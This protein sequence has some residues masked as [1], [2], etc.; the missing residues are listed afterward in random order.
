MTRSL[1]EQMPADWKPTV[2]FL[3]AIGDATLEEAWERLDDAGQMLWLCSKLH[4][5]PPERLAWA[6]L[7]RARELAQA[8]L[9]SANVPHDALRRI[10]PITDSAHAAAITLVVDR[11]WADFLHVSM[12][13]ETA[14]MC[15]EA[16]EALDNACRNT[17]RWT[18]PRAQSVGSTLWR[19]AFICGPAFSREEGAAF[20]AERAERQLQAP[21]L[22]EHV[23]VADLRAALERVG[24]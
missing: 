20:A 14:S 7:E 12:R 1:R 19:M 15:S 4:V 10:D 23:D 13:R 16:L 6:W 8:A 17:V 21:A 2:G 18:R 5:E 3:E 11:V 24:R 9:Q 22:R